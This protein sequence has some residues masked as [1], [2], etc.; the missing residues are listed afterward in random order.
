MEK[1]PV[2]VMLKHNTE[3]MFSGS[4]C[5]KH[6]LLDCRHDLDKEYPE[7]LEVVKN[8]MHFKL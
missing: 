2:I 8:T 4:C 6:K 1:C 5:T 3:L 7:A